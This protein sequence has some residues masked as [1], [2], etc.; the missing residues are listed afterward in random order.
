MTATTTSAPVPQTIPS[1]AIRL[2]AAAK[3][4]VRPP[5]NATPAWKAAQMAE[6]QQAVIAFE[7]A[8]PVVD[9]VIQEETSGSDY[10]EAPPPD[11]RL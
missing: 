3:L 5:V 1:Y 8:M 4:V 7:A 2:L 6:L 9:G 10:I 11:W